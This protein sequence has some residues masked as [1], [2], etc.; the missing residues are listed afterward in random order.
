MSIIDLY[1]DTNNLEVIKHEDNHFEIKNKFNKKG[2]LFDIHIPAC[3]S[4]GGPTRLLNDLT[5][6]ASDKFYNYIGQ[7]IQNKNC[8]NVR[9][10]QSFINLTRI[11]SDIASKTAFFTAF[12]DESPMTLTQMLAT[13]DTEKD[14][15]KKENFDPLWSE[16]NDIIQFF[17]N[18]DL[19]PYEL[20]INPFCK[21]LGRCHD[22]IS[23]C[24][25]I[26][27]INQHY[28]TAN[29]LYDHA[30]T[31][32][33]FGENRNQRRNKLTSVQL[34]TNKL[35]VWNVIY[36]RPF[37]NMIHII[38]ITR[39]PQNELPE[40]YEQ[41]KIG[42]FLAFCKYL[43]DYFL[44]GENTNKNKLKDLKELDDSIS[45]NQT[46]TYEQNIDNVI[47]IDGFTFIPKK[48]YESKIEFR[49]YI[50]WYTKQNQNNNNFICSLSALRP[51]NPDQYIPDKTD[52]IKKKKVIGQMVYPMGS[53][54]FVIK[55]F[56]YVQKKD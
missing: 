2:K 50:D 32:G 42:N 19:L 37:K 5:C 54:V 46:E 20:R 28:P 1:Q 4:I 51:P 22:L 21:S 45:L 7:K 35:Q 26:N 38:K 48:K 40:G 44:I 27:P 10:K 14:E 9:Y 17:E 34:N 49:Q 33:V 15:F 16:P 39:K 8:V 31:N 52:F 36:T 25:G 11:N 41:K 6:G 23:I 30:N 29:F 18:N 47:T 55:L 3:T 53:V 12:H 24:L 56:L 13:W 43:P